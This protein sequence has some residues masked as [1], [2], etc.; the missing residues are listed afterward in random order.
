MRSP[1]ARW[2]WQMT[3]PETIDLVVDANIAQSSGHSEDQTSIN[4]REFLEILRDFGHRIVM[5]TDIEREWNDHYSGF[6]TDWLTTMTTTGKVHNLGNVQDQELRNKIELSAPDIHI[7]KIM[8]KDTHL[9]EAALVTDMTV[10]SSDKR[11][12]GHFCHVCQHIEE[13]RAV[14]WVNPVVAEDACAGWLKQGAPEEA[15]TS[16]RLPSQ[17]PVDAA[18]DLRPHQRLARNDRPRQERVGTRSHAPRR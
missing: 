16:I 13:I 10:A 8:Q 5:S 7:F 15:E 3:H 12:H 2:A 18:P 1:S 11:V 14:M 17:K 4:S 9:L 6:S